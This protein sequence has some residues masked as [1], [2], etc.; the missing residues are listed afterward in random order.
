MI[1]TRF[2]T[3]EGTFI[4]LGYNDFIKEQLIKKQRLLTVDEIIDPFTEYFTTH[5]PF[6]K[7]LDTESRF[8]YNNFK[9]AIKYKDKRI[10]FIYVRTPEDKDGVTFLKRFGFGDLID[11]LEA[12]AVKKATNEKTKARIYFFN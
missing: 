9:I 6:I 4:V 5:P 1:K 3:N 10:F 12:N 8:Q 11:K 7:K 2:W